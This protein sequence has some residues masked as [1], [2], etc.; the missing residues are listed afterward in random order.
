MEPVFANYALDHL[1]WNL[2]E[3]SYNT[4]SITSKL[5]NLSQASERGAVQRLL[6]RP[7]SLT[8]RELPRIS[9]YRFISRF[10]SLTSN[11]ICKLA[12]HQ[13]CGKSHLLLQNQFSQ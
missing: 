3:G 1:V 5:Q 12:Y 8:H 7:S 9:S 11:S 13:D 10:A 6:E 4:I 2:D